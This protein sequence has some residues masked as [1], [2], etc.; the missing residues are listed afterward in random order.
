M[1][2]LSQLKKELRSNSYSF[3]KALRKRALKSKDTGA[4]DK[5]FKH[6]PPVIIAD[7][8]YQ[9][10]VSLLDYGKYVHYQTNKQRAVGFIDEAINDTIDRI[11]YSIVEQEYENLI[12]EFKIKRK[13]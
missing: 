3:Y 10:E 9:M 13:K 5:S 8:H 2:K 12:E 6:H 4:L 7:G 11:K 1:R